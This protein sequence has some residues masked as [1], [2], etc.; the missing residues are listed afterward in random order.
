MN[1]LSE[2]LQLVLWPL[3]R[4]LGM[5]S[6]FEDRL[7]LKLASQS[8]KLLLKLFSVL[9]FFLMVRMIHD[10]WYVISINSSSSKAVVLRQRWSLVL[11]ELELVKS[12]WDDSRVRVWS[13]LRH[14]CSWGCFSLCNWAIGIQVY[15]IFLWELDELV[16]VDFAVSIQINVQ[17][18]FPEI[19]RSELEAYSLKTICELI[20]SKVA[21]VFSVEESEGSI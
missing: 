7:I 21:L 3:D 5:L 12:S 2:L 13:M 17:E 8:F 14:T 20:E 9:H 15:A 6:I 11:L 4:P 1:H 18:N 19:L 10:L 16:K